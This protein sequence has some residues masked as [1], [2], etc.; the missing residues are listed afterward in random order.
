MMYSGS[1]VWCYQLALG[2]WMVV[3]LAS[4]NVIGSRGSVTVSDPF[5]LS[6]ALNSTQYPQYKYIVLAN[7]TGSTYVLNGTMTFLLSSQ[8]VSITSPVGHSTIRYI[9]TLL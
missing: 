4:G 3:W 1:V 9:P 8:R 6:M 2:L 5:Q 7:A